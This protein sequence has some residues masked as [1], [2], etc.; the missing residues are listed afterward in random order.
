VKSKFTGTELSPAWSQ[1]DPLL[2]SLCEAHLAFPPRTRA[3]PPLDTVYSED[4]APAKLSVSSSQPPKPRPRKLQVLWQTL[5]LVCAPFVFLHPLTI[6]YGRKIWCLSF[7]RPAGIGRSIVVFFPSHRK[8]MPALLKTWR[9]RNRL[10]LFLL[11]LFGANLR[12]FRRRRQPN[13]NAA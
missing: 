10:A 6:R 7:I 5:P 3:R 1:T 9:V 2:T 8:F 13:F 11:L 4:P 12:N